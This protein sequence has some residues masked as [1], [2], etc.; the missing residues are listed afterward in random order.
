MSLK[1]VHQIIIFAGISISL[2]FA[3]FCFTDPSAAGNAWYLVAGIGS[4]FAALALVGYEIYFLR[5][6]RRLII[7]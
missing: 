7:N 2:F 5:K 3:W 4:I 6:T 1:F